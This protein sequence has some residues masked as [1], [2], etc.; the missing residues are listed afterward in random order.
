MRSDSVGRA[1]V[2]TNPFAWTDSMPPYGLMFAPC[3]NTQRNCAK[4]MNVACREKTAHSDDGRDVGILP[5]PPRN[6]FQAFHRMAP[7]CPKEREL[8]RIV[9]NTH[10]LDES[11]EQA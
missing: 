11:R 7:G 6:P 8:L 3:W 9:G 4:N 1:S 2:G 10:W 5:Q